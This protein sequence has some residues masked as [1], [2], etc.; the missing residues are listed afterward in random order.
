MAFDLDMI[1]GIYA[2][3]QERVKAALK[4]E[5]RPLT[6]SEKILYPQ[7]WEVTS[8]Q[9]YERGR[10]DIDLAPICVRQQDVRAHIALL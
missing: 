8:A 6:L 10:L 2:R 5:G 7:L 1:K 9:V 3:M 4:M